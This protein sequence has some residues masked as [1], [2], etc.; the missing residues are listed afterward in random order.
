MSKIINVDG[1]PMGSNGTG[2]L[3]G[4]VA[5]GTMGNK[6]V[7]LS[8]LSKRVIRLSP[9]EMKEMELKTICGADWCEEHYTHLHPKKEIMVFDH[10]ALATH[11]I[12]DCQA[13]GPYVESYER[14][15]GIWRMSDGGLVVNGR[16]VWRP[17]GTV[18]EHGIHE[19]RVYPASGDVGFDLSTPEADDSEV[20]RILSAFGAIQWRHAL[21][22]ELILGQVALMFVCSALRRRP[23]VLLTGAAGVGK[24]TVLELVKWLVGPC[25][26]VCTGPQTLAGYYQAVGGTSKAIILDEF[27]A[28]PKKA[29]VAVTF[30][31]ARMAYSLQEGDEGIVRGTPGGAKKSYR[32][33]SPFMAAGVSPG[34]MEPADLTR[35]V[36]LEAVARKGDG[37]QLTEEEARVMGP[38]LARRFIS[39][40]GVFQATEGMIRECVV[41]AGGDGRMAD[42][43]GTLL[44]CYWTMV[45]SKPATAED[46]EVL[47]GMLDIKARVE[48]HGETDEQRCL[49]ALFTRVLP[50]KFMSDDALV[51]RSLAI[52]EAVQRVCDDP[53]GTPEIVA[54]L[55]QL[56]IRVAMVKGEWKVF[57]ANSPEH[58]ELK[59]LFAGT[60]WA[61]GGWSTVLRRLRGGEE[62]TQRIGSGFKAA[63][64]TVFDVPQ[65]LLPAQNDFEQL[66]AA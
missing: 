32:F 53:T 66:L 6:C 21:G 54:R 36:V 40:W 56:G 43:V 8:K 22:A 15:A 1:T 51:T 30:E 12:R 14:A 37:P 31:V 11:I 20:Q 7:L 28:D 16:S 57:I 42:T 34:K 2:T 26:H 25:A 39:R 9:S 3:G 64:V 17:D 49:E 13:Q 50:F 33:F 19:G 62:S 46:A 5:L 41:A 63:K 10:R 38:R 45:S 44:A 60:K 18:M 52:S 65:E 48:M 27:E 47:V 24:S 4:Y 59:R 35:W 29:N 55:A 58:Q 23:H 61:T